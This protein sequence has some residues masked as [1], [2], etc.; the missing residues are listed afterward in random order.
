MFFVL[1]KFKGQP[2]PRLFGTTHLDDCYALATMRNVE[3]A[4]HS[5]TGNGATLPRRE[6]VGRFLLGED[7]I[8]P[9]LPE[10]GHQHL[11]RVQEMAPKTRPAA[12]DAISKVTKGSHPDDTEA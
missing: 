4:S 10:D 3:W 7:K 1:V 11:R 9:I 6:Y 2:E 8:I 5:I 12:E